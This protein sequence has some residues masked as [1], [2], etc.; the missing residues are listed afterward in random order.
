MSV[1]KSNVGSQAR[2]LYRSLLR[3]G[4]QFANYNFREYAK[5]RTR[6]AFRENQAITE[7]RKVQEMMQKGLQ[8]LQVLKRQTV[9]SQMFQFDKLVVEGGK[10]GKQ[11]GRKGDIVRQKDQGWFRPTGRSARSGRVQAEHDV[12]EGLPVRQWRQVETTVGAPPGSTTQSKKNAWPELS[13][14]RESHLLP[15]HSQ[16]LLRAA[17]A[18]WL[19]K[20]TP[21]GAEEDEKENEDEEPK[22]SERGFAVKK[23]SVVPRHLE[24]PEREYLAKR[25]KGLA[26][27]TNGLN[28]DGIAGGPMRKTKVQKADADGNLKIYEVLVPEGQTVEGEVLNEE[29]IPE[30]VPVVVPPAVPGT[31]VE[32]VG[33]VN[34]EGLVVAG[35]L[36]APV[37][38]K[39]PPPRRKPKRSGP[40]RGRKKVVI[41][42]STENA[43]PGTEGAADPSKL[44]VPPLGNVES[45]SAPSADGDTPMGD[46]GD[47]D[48][49]ESE[50]GEEGDKDDR[51]DGE[52]SSGVEDGEGATE[53]PTIPASEQPPSIAI[54][55]TSPDVAPSTH[56]SSQTGGV[57]TSD[58][59]L[60]QP[61]DSDLLPSNPSS[62]INLSSSATN[63]LVTSDTDIPM[64]SGLTPPNKSEPSKSNS[65]E[66]PL[67]ETQDSQGPLREDISVT[68]T[69]S[70]QPEPPSEKVAS[71]V[72]PETEPKQE[73]PVDES[74][75]AA[76]EISDPE[77]KPGALVTQTVE[78]TQEAIEIVSKPAADS[79]DLFGSL[80]RHLAGESAEEPSDAA[81]ETTVAD[82]MGETA[83]PPEVSEA[84]EE[85]IAS[86]AVAEEK[87]GSKDAGTA[88]E[89][90]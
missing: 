57:I 2:S 10:T 26:T 53:V 43:G 82:A 71:P 21:G 75:P 64:T 34:E 47:E 32:G 80:E 18:G 31:I 48:D 23:W 40:G 25:R 28:I 24:E 33:V 86:K 15:E 16:Q 54:S 52:L 29:A 11:T 42:P 38:R 55:R 44:T 5:R 45:S 7:E 77:T 76:A 3:Q 83:A 69:T 12:F 27:S 41:E 58:A 13:M 79:P 87:S 90:A 37:K 74:A 60:T 67:A 49:E 50:D 20:A 4:N 35:E 63:L 65:P 9:I 51:E 19:Y 72:V 68:P 8:E 6:D 78:E 85:E 61:T 17:R 46:A 30:N 89:G 36:P 66:M 14:P 1:A 59:M 70:E 39:P 22:E 56:S 88:G 84:L 81:V 73:D 62:D